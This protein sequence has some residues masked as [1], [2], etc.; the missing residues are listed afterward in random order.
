MVYIPVGSTSIKRYSASD[1]IIFIQTR[2]IIFDQSP[3]NILAR[4]QALV[5]ACDTHE[6]LT[7]S[8]CSQVKILIFEIKSIKH[9]LLY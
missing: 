2:D 9:L 4:C 8:L 6:K 5:A 3:S 7:V 1:D